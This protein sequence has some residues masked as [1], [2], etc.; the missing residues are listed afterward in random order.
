MTPRTFLPSSSAR[1]AEDQNCPSPSLFASSPTSHP[2][3]I[4]DAGLSEVSSLDEA[5]YEFVERIVARPST[6]HESGESLEVLPNI[7]E[8]EVQSDIS[9]LEQ[10]NTGIEDSHRDKIAKEKVEIWLSGS[11]QK[12]KSRP[13]SI[14]G[15]ETFDCGDSTF[16]NSV[17]L[18]PS[19]VNT[20]TADT[21]ADNA[22]VDFS[23]GVRTQPTETF[24]SQI[25]QQCKRDQFAPQV[26]KWALIVLSCVLV[27]ITSGT[28]V[29]WSPSERPSAI[30]TTSPVQMT[31]THPAETSV[32]M[33]SAVKSAV[34]SLS[35]WSPPVLHR[36]SQ[37][38]KV[39]NS[40]NTTSLILLTRPN[41]LP[42]QAIGHIQRGMVASNALVY[43]QSDQLWAS[44][45]DFVVAAAA[46]AGRVQSD[47]RD[48]WAFWND[49]LYR[50]WEKWIWPL[51]EEMTQEVYQQLSTAKDKSVALSEAV[52]IRWTRMSASAEKV[53]HDLL[54]QASLQAATLAE[55]TQERVQGIT[56]Q[57]S[58]NAHINL[59]KAGKM[60]R[61]T[62]KRDI[63]LRA[64]HTQKAHKE[65][66]GVRRWIKQIREW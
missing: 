61:Q 13:A 11:E 19:S 29:F 40:N 6:S 23:E 36:A 7:V 50:L 51:I 52:G 54:L 37:V 10:G 60:A 35:T 42:G 25:R 28:T 44:I 21:L 5:D 58:R 56:Q 24:A 59:G 66:V 64:H 39:A 17:S 15:S 65:P 18:T 26:K 27:W 49:Q 63:D 9:T 2:P 48:E 53:A 46:Q 31:A 20:L 43:S 47:A 12:A 4:N 33:P 34:V 3:S 41:E 30:K 45:E 8:H 1:G 16:N 38:I 32:S 55:K 57:A 14:G 22:K 62:W